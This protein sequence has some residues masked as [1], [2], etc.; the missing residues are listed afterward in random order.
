MIFAKIGTVG[1]V[2]SIV[3]KFALVCRCQLDDT[4]LGFSTRWNSAIFWDRD[5]SLATGR[6]GI[7]CQNLG[8][9]MP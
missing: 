1:T 4:E 6:A 7:A 2:T 3:M 9:D 8:W 5:R